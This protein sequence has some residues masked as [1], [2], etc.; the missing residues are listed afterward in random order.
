MR[1]NRCYLSCNLDWFREVRV[2]RLDWL[3]DFLLV[4]RKLLLLLGLGFGLQA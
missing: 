1:T 2:L 4:V 3:V